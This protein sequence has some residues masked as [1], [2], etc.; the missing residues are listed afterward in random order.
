MTFEFEIFAAA[1]FGIVDIYC[2]Y[3]LLNSNLTF[4][5][6][7]KKLVWVYAGIYVLYILMQTLMGIFSAYP[8]KLP[9]T[10]LFYISLFI[11]YSDIFYVKILWIF[12]SILTLALCELACMPIIRLITHIPF[13]D[14]AQTKSAYC[15]GM[16]LSRTL[17]LLLVCYFTHSKYARKRIFQG[18]SKEIFTIII[19]DGIYL[20]LLFNLFYYNAFYLDANTAIVLSLFVL[21]LVSILSIYLLWKVMRKS[22]E[23]MNTT[24]KLQQAEMEHKLTSDMTS[25]VE[26]LRSLRHDMNNHMSIL[27]GLLSVGAYDDM[28]AYLNSLTQELSVANNFYF[29]ENKV[30]SVLLNSKISKATQLGITF[31]TEILTSKTP[32]SERDLCAVIG[33]VLENAN[34][35]SSKHTEPYIYFTMYQKEQQLYIQCDNTYTTAPIFENG[36]LLT[37]KENKTTHG[38]GTQN[39]NSI[40]ES[41]HGIVIFSV[42]ERFH[43]AISIPV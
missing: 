32:F 43:V 34:E 9:L 3:R 20:T 28:A 12:G 39:I 40:V 24:L 5:F 7:R 23:I 26:N 1:F 13:E 36:K 11:I 15:T 29:P 31:E 38:I 27:Q 33:N 14:I 25:V 19:I 8:I 10:L 17:F 16:V 22:E 18:F 4:R 42:D 35:A 30:L 37:T 21:I 41:Y 2:I 6:S